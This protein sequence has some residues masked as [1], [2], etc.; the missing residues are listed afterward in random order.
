MSARNWQGIPD[1]LI[2]AVRWQHAT[3]MQAGEKRAGE[4]AVELLTGKVL[5]D[6]PEFARLI[7]A[8]YVRTLVS[9]PKPRRRGQPGEHEHQMA[10]C[11]R[12]HAEGMSLRAIGRA[13]G[14]SHGR[15]RSLL[16]EW[17]TRLPEMDAGLIRAATPLEAPAVSPQAALEAPELTAEVYSYPNVTPLRRLA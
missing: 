8:R 12:M 4:N 1:W 7:V 10:R 6:D 2:Y 11:A 3:A 13:E 9:A 14:I 15:A 5:A 16:A 17:V